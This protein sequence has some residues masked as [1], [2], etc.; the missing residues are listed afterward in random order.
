VFLFSKARII[1]TRNPQ[2]QW[3]Q[4]IRVFSRYK[5]CRNTSN[6]FAQWC[7]TGP[8]IKPQSCATITVFLY[9]YFNSTLTVQL[10]TKLFLCLLTPCLNFNYSPR[11]AGCEFNQNKI[12]KTTQQT[13]K[14]V[15]I[16]IEKTSENTLRA[17]GL[18]TR[19]PIIC[20]R[21]H[22]TKPNFVNTSSLLITP[23]KAEN[24]EPNWRQSKVIKIPQK[25]ESENTQSDSME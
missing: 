22:Q 19:T 3:H 8:L 17:K 7:F 9:G 1:N 6:S 5:R 21:P 4:T 13:P 12:R 25:R 16:I 15:K 24:K 11:K 2:V 23:A 14:G 10:G 20:H 18:P